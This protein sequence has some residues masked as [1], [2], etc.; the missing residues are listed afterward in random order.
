[1]PSGPRYKAR[2]GARVMPGAPNTRDEHDAK[3]PDC[4]GVAVECGEAI[5]P[6]NVR[7]VL[8][9]GTQD[10]ESASERTLRVRMT[11]VCRQAKVACSLLHA[12]GHMQPRDVKLAQA[13]LGQIGPDRASGTTPV[14][15]ERALDVR[16]DT[17]SILVTPSERRAG[18]AI[19]QLGRARE[20]THCL[21]GI[22]GDSATVPVTSPEFAQGD[23]TAAA[24]SVPE[25]A[26]SQVGV[27]D[28]VHADQGRAS[29]HR[30]IRLD[31]LGVVRQ[32]LRCF[33]RRRAKT[34]E[35]C[36]GKP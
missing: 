30:S 11:L 15:L 20:K 23:G 4:I 1:M 9:T 7:R 3:P 26:Y 12:V 25:P 18:L 35:A 31:A 27:L 16:F 10:L 17:A 34:S 29:V 21:G 22:T 2:T 36:E 33:D 13:I 24:R 5:I 28:P 32:R 14:K 19:A 6:H 8:V